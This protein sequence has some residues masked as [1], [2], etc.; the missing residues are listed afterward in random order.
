MRIRIDGMTIDDIGMQALP[1]CNFPQ[2]MAI[3]EAAPPPGT[4]PTPAQMRD[5]LGESRRDSTRASRIG[6]AEVR[7]LS[8]DTPEGPF[9]LAAIRL[10]NLENGKLAEFA[11]EGLDARSPQGPVKIGRF[12]LKSLDIANLMRMSAQF[13]TS[14]PRTRSRISSPHCCC[15]SKAPRSANL[16]APYKD[17][18]P[19][20]QHRHAEHLLGPVRRADPD[21]GARHPEDVRP[22]GRGRSGSVQHARRCR[23]DQ[24][25]DQFRS[26]RRVE[27]GHARRSRSSR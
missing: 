12:A 6:G 17:D 21:A 22:G 20:G 4:T 8:M 3:I 7:G 16:V 15:C 9:R 13:A 2:L 25:V 23:H 5:L 10:G 19:A 18:E 24:R 1:S 27:R 14:R 11:L 26:R